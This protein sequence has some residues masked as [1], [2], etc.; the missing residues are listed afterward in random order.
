MDDRPK[1][2]V[3]RALSSVRMTV[4]FG[5]A[6]RAVTAPRERGRCPPPGHGRNLRLSTRNPAK[7]TRVSYN[8]TVPP[9]KQLMATVPGL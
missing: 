9:Y 3:R 8:S 5:I 4:T 1:R 7:H 2:R 6:L